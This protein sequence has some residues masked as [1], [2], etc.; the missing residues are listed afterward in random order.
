MKNEKQNIFTNEAKN[1]K[2]DFKKM[3]DEMPE[4]DFIDMILYLL[5]SRSKTTLD[6]LKQKILN[7]N[8]K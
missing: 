5:N 4:E 6:P 1:L 7:K 3:I 8:K 2:N